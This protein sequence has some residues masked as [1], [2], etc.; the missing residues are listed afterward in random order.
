M[1]EREFIYSNNSGKCDLCCGLCRWSML[2]LRSTLRS[3]LLATC[4]LN[5]IRKY[6]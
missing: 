4:H 5:K 3:M 2:V 1:N 6:K